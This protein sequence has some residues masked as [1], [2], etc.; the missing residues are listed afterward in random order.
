MMKFPTIAMQ[1][2][3]TA[4]ELHGYE[5]LVSIIGRMQNVLK[6]K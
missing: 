2:T 3:Y 5:R 1:I 6:Q 4:T